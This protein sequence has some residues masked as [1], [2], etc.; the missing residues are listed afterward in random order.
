MIR[1]TLPLLPLAA[2]LVL[3]VTCLTSS[4]SHAEKVEASEPGKAPAS[5]ALTVPVAEASLTPMSHGE[6]LTAEFRPFQEIELMAK[7]SGYVKKITVDV[8][9]H[10]Q[11][12]QVLAELEIPEMTDDLARAKAGVARAQADVVRAKDE[13][14]RAETAHE[15]THLSAKR[16]ADVAKQKV[17][18]VAQQEV[19]DA[20][21]KDLVAEA[22][23]QTAKSS[24]AGAEQQV[25]V[26]ETE[27]KRV[28]TMLDYTTITAP[29]AGVV[30]KRYADTG[31]M[32]QAGTSSNAMPLIRLSENSMLRLT[33][34][35]PES[36][37]P[38][39]HVGQQVDVRVPT[40][41]RAFSGRVARFADKVVQSTRTM[42]TEVDVPNPSRV[43]VPGMFAEVNLTLDKRASVLTV[44]I[45]AVDIG[46]DESAGQVT[47]VTP[48]NKIEVRKVKLGQQDNLNV[49]VLSGL[50]AGDKVVTSN[51]STLKVG[52]E[53]RP[54][55]VALGTG[56]SSK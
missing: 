11:Q 17:G 13:E 28:Q 34:P 30:T 3:G 36:I 15:I 37:V 23:I 51:R 6:V 19:D 45:P 47:V 43:L 55:L 9:D 26:A 29:F 35:V 10:V 48:E 18:L 40:L 27:V 22:Q 21:N 14:Q 24:M 31:S 33:V 50:S 49:E 7:V 52:Q 20:R 39:V 25:R 8:G 16:L 5:Q 38:S 1:R 2:G 41:N 53:V 4:C 56:S 12:G 54:K 32:L 44:P 42:D 46:S